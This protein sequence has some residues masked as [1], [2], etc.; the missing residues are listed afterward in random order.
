MTLANQARFER[1]KYTFP[2]REDFA[3][4]Y[5]QRAKHTSGLTVWAPML[6]GMGLLQ[7]VHG[8]RVVEL[9]R[10]RQMLEENVARYLQIR[11]HV[12]PFALTHGEAIQHFRE[13]E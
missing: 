1:W 8:R 2:A 13:I 11:N 4:I 7:P 5:T 10:H 6:C 9:S 12:V 3:P